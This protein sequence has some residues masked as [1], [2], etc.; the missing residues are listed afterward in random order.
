[1]QMSPIL[2]MHSSGR[3]GK[4]KGETYSSLLC[5]IRQE[6]PDLNLDFLKKWDRERVREYLLQFKGVDSKPPPS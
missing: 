2:L 1:M 4:S 6:H 5:Q 3:V